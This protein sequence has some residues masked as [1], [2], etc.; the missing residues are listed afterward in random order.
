M[1][2]QQNNKEESAQE[3]FSTVTLFSEEMIDTDESGD[4]GCFDCDG[5]P[6][7]KE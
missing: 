5:T 1:D 4:C 3:V 7:D 6:C 2:R